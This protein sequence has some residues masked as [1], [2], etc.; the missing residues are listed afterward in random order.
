MDEQTI[1]QLFLD[2]PKLASQLINKNTLATLIEDTSTLY[3]YMLKYPKHS[4]I[5][6]KEI[7]R[8]NLKYLRILN[9]RLGYEQ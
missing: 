6:Q 9:Q 3:N 4:E 7:V 8:Q 2:S 1:E 5:W